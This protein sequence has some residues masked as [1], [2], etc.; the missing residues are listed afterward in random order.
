M[1]YIKNKGKKCRAG[2]CRSGAKALG[3]CYKHWQRYRRYGRTTLMVKRSGIPY[4]SS[5]K[6]YQ[7]E[8]QLKY[9]LKFSPKSIQAMHKKRFGGLR[10]AVIKRDNEQ[11]VECGMTRKD[12]QEKWGRDITVDHYD[13]MGR[14]SVEQN[15]RLNNLQ[16]LCL[17]CHGKKDIMRAIHMKGGD[18]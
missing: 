2:N 1:K 4:K 15:N 14:Y 7:R 3:L 16:T 5:T 13:G 8:Y 9:R 11:C 12:H 10:E 6:E 18:I 17:S